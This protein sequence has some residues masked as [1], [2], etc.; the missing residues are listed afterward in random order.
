MKTRTVLA[1]ATTVVLLTIPLLASD[2]PSDVLKQRKAID[3]D[4]YAKMAETKRHLEVDIKNLKVVFDKEPVVIKQ[5][6]E[7]TLR[8]YMNMKAACQAYRTDPNMTGQEFLS[9]IQE[10][11]DKQRAIQKAIIG[12]AVSIRMEP[13]V[14]V[15]VVKGEKKE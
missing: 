8:L 9:K 12:L 5:P 4:S 1:F 15:S 2:P 13:T 10:L 7:E 11:E 3:C 6:S 14:K